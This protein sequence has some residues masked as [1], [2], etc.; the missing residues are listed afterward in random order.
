M[1][2]LTVGRFQRSGGTVSPAMVAAAT[3]ALKLLAELADDDG[4][5][6]ETHAARFKNLMHNLEVYA[7]LRSSEGM[8]AAAG[9]A[10]EAARAKAHADKMV[11]SLPKLWLANDG[12]FATEWRENSRYQRGLA[13]LNPNGTAQLYGLA[14]LAPKRECWT[15]VER[16]FA[17]ESTPGTRAGVERWL[18]AATRFGGDDVADWRRKTVDEVYQVPDCAIHRAGLITLGLLEGADWMP[19][20]A[21][22]NSGIPMFVPG[23]PIEVT[24]MGIGRGWSVDAAPEAD[25]ATMH[26]GLWIRRVVAADP[27]EEHFVKLQL[28]PIELDT[29]KRLTPTARPGENRFLEGLIR[30]KD[31]KTARGNGGPVVRLVLD[32]PDRGAAKIKSLKGTA[33]VARVKLTPLELGDADALIG[34]KVEHPK[35]EDF[36]IR[37]SV[38][39]RDGTTTLKLKLPSDDDRVAEWGLVKGGRLLPHRLEQR[40]RMEGVRTLTKIYDGLHEK[41]ATLRLILAEPVETETIEFE[42]KDLQL[43]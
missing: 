35:L 30:T 17:P 13:R 39:T 2:L 4:L 3:K 11:G 18:M 27:A 37:A 1:F 36:P 41:T 19:S 34:K 22:E 29:G 10:T 26:V 5:T 33:T 42:F 40:K 6:W 16:E 12:L 20:V 25:I 15:A 32:A 7:G 21:Q 24:D 43:P 31:W 28:E 8:F 9:A 23:G 14:F 38:Y